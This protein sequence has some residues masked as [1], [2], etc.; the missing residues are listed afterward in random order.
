[1]WALGREFKH[2]LNCDQS[3]KKGL[4]EQHLFK[5]V[6]EGGFRGCSRYFPVT[7]KV[8][9]ERARSLES[10]LWAATV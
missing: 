4:V 3:L 2:D 8:T 1:M 7:L 6:D 9:N 10:V 5:M